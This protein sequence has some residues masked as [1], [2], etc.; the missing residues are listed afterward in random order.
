MLAENRHHRVR[1]IKNRIRELKAKWHNS[2]KSGGQEWLEQTA[3]GKDN[4][5]TRCSCEMCQGA[6]QER[7]ERRRE[8]KQARLEVQREL[9]RMEAENAEDNKEYMRLMR[10]EEN[11]AWDGYWD[12]Y[13]GTRRTDAQDS[14]RVRHA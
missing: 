10:L 1:V 12:E 7:D 3:K 14:L 8:R 11:F 4:P 5:F 2:A 6:R 13:T 9:T